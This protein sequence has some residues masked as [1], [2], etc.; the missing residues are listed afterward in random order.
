M[1]LAAIIYL[2]RDVPVSFSVPK[3]GPDVPSVERL[4]MLDFAGLYFELLCEGPAEMRK[5]FESN[6]VG[7]FRNT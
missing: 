4:M 3:F 6:A 2:I 7:H 5:I 1:V